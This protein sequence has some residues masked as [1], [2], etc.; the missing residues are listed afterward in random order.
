VFA[1]DYQGLG[2]IITA[3]FAGIASV[4]AAWNVRQTARVVQNVTTRN[5]DSRTMGETVSD[6]AEAVGSPA[7]E[8]EPAH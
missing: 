2:I 6:V 5:G 1:T 3:V 4:V 7:P 8:E